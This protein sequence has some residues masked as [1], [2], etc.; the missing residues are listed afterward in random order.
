[1][2]RTPG[3]FFGLLL[4]TA[5]V[6]QKGTVHGTITA[7]EADAAQPMPFVNVAIK[8]TTLGAT[9][10]M[11]GSYSF[12]V[13]AGTYVLQVSFVG[14]EPVERPIAVPAGGAVTA[15]IEL[16]KQA[17]A[18]RT[19][20]GGATRRTDTEGAVLMETRRSMQVMNAVSSETISKSQ[21]SDAG[22]VMRRVPGVTMI[23]NS[24][25]MVRGLNERYSNVQLHDVSAPSMEPDVR[26]F[27]F[28]IIP[29]GL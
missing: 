28:D 7:P 16:R 12:Q 5:A 9:T 24:H 22:E 3:I 10:G 11:D 27:A 21:D 14:Y 2:K 29:A 23:G 20:E 1:M 15:H 19:V 26:S 18:M 6:A 25:V 8:G 13:D 4:T 17:V